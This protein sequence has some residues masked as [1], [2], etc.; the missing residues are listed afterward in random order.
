MMF[1]AKRNW[2][3]LWGKLTI[4]HI[5]F[6][7]EISDNALRDSSHPYTDLFD[8][9]TTTS[10][11]LSEMLAL[12]PKLPIDIDDSNSQASLL[13]PFLCLNSKITYKH[14]GQYCKGFLGKCDSV[15]PFVFKLHKNKHKDN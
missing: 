12:I 2:P 13:P 1:G 15:D 4:M 8:D 11:A 3:N 14:K 5:L 6:L 7:I 10:I 9:G